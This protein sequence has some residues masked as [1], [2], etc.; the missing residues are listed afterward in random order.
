MRFRSVMRSTLVLS[1]LFLSA[2]AT[3]RATGPLEEFRGYYEHGFE[4]ESFRRC[5]SA[6]AWWVVQPDELFRRSREFTTAQYQPVFAVVRGY[7]GP[8]GRYG[9]MGVYTRQL[10]VVEVVD[11]R[12]ASDAE[13][14]SA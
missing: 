3:S 10:T 7:T 12:P 11:V 13:C 14:L 2:C 9:H 8:E 4:V 6:E 1:M 5:G